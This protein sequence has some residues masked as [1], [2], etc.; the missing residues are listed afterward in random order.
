MTTVR[1]VQFDASGGEI[2]KSLKNKKFAKL[3]TLS[4]LTQVLRAP[5]A[6]RYA[7]SLCAKLRQVYNVKCSKFTECET[8]RMAKWTA[9]QS[10]AHWYRVISSD[11]VDSSTGHSTTFGR[12]QRLSADGQAQASRRP[13][14]WTVS[15][16]LY[17]VNCIHTVYSTVSLLQTVANRCKRLQ[18]SWIQTN[19]LFMDYQMTANTFKRE[20]FLSRS[21]L[22]RIWAAIGTVANARVRFRMLK[23]RDWRD[24]LIEDLL[25]GVRRKCWEIAET[26]GWD[27]QLRHPSDSLR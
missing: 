14:Q 8:V 1:C 3:E 25:A 10:N 16:G 11:T 2:K 18:T 9:R 23:P 26:I 19:H 27:Y 12:I 24:L 15:S 20:P 6:D 13:I 22:C 7:G 4:V 5:C 17:P 21:G